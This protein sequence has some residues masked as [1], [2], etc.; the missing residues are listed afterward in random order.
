MSRFNSPVRFLPSRKW[1][2]MTGFHFPPITSSVAS[3]P[4]LYTL[5][6]VILL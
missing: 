2:R 5:V 1:Q 3:T 4:I 6:I